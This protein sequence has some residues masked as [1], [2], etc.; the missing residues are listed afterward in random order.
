MH[1]VNRGTG[2]QLTGPSQVVREQS[3][4]FS[5]DGARLQ[6]QGGQGL[7]RPSEGSE[8]GARG[9]QAPVCPG[10]APAGGNGEL[11]AD[12][13]PGF[14]NPVSSAQARPSASLVC[15]REPSSVNGA[16]SPILLCS[17]W[18]GPDL[19]ASPASVSPSPSVCFL[20][21]PWVLVPQGPVE[22][23]GCAQS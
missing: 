19:G 9:P 22:T 13:T 11:L 3:C 17:R 7:G 20:P 5:I 8:A 10:P 18:P 15:Y 1:P 2:G 16:P 23:P 21:T 4:S 12:R 14:S 6:L